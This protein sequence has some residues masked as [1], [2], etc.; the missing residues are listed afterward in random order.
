MIRTH[1]KFI[2]GIFTL[3]NLFLGVM[4]IVRTF[5][6]D[7]SMAAWL[8]IFAVLADGMD[9][10]IARWI[11]QESRFGFEL[12]SLADTV[13]FCV[14]PALLVYFSQINNTGWIAFIPVFMYIF[15][16]V[17]RLARFNVMQAG[18][19]SRGYIGLP[20][21]VPAMLVS[22]GIFLM[23][24]KLF[25][26]MDVSWFLLMPFLAG[27]MISTIPYDWPKLAF[28]GSIGGKIKSVWIILI[29]FGMIFWPSYCL[30]PA[31]FG[32]IL[33]GIANHFL[34]IN[35]KAWKCLQESDRSN[36]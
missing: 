22:S 7:Y 25:G 24:L 31:L 3:L 2:P 34:K 27:L 4:A 29:L 32:Y 23:D 16:G 12:D 30:F 14:A 1:H 10:K 11:D 33:F 15:A 9:G 26:Q 17:F 21:P 20:V 18:D 13:S 35:P 5:E 6:N 28:H 8:I 36:Y 19:R